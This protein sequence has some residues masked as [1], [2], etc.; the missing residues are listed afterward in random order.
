MLPVD[1][2]NLTMPGE[3]VKNVIRDKLDSQRRLLELVRKRKFNS[4]SYFWIE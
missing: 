4:N 1:I 3:F 2:M